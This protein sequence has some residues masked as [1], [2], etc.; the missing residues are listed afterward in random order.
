MSSAAATTEL[1]ASHPEF[2][3]SV[4][5]NG[6]LLPTFPAPSG[7]ARAVLLLVHPRLLFAYW[8]IDEHLDRRLRKLAGSAQLRVEISDGSSPFEEVSRHDFDFRTPH[9]YLHNSFIDSL[10][11]VRLG[12]VVRGHFEELLVSNP[13]R[14]PRETPGDEPEIWMKLSQLRASPPPATELH[15]TRVKGNKPAVKVIGYPPIAKG[16]YGRIFRRL[17][18][19]LRREMADKAF[20]RGY[21]SVVLHSHLPFVRHP[22][23]DYFLEE[24]WL[25]EAITETYLPLL[26]MFDRLLADQ[27]PARVTVSLSPTLVAMLRDPH[28]MGKYERHLNKLCELG[29]KEV[30]RTERDATFGPI[31]RFYL[32]HFRRLRSLFHDRYQRDLVGECA[33]LEE[34]GLLE[35]ITCASTHGFLPFLSVQPE[36]VWAQ[37]QTA[38]EEHERHFGRRPRGIWL[39]ECAYTEGM[40]EMLVDAG[41][42]FF[43]VDSHAVRNASSLPKFGTFAPVYCP[44]GV[45]AFCRDDESSVQ[46]WSSELGYPGDPAYRDFYRDI[47]FDLD[48]SYVGP[49]LDPAGIRGMTGF[50]YYRV[51]GRNNN[52]EPYRR[53]WALS[54]AESHAEDFAKNRSFQLG[55]VAGRMERVPLVCAMYDAELFGHWWFEG[56]EWL[57]MVLRKLPSRRLFAVTPSQYLDL[58]PIGQVAEPAGSSWGEKGY[59]EVWLN[60]SNDWVYPH[61][62]DA[63]RRFLD[64]LGRYPNPTRSIA[65]GLRQAGRELLLGQASD[66]P[67]IL[68]TGTSVGYARRRIHEHLGRLNRLLQQLENGNVDENQIAQMEEADN[69]FP[70]LDPL[71]TWR[72]GGAV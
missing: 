16:K 50:K 59:F 38:L 2:L 51:T 5:G 57:E 20:A 71:R 62:H 49:Y 56:P 53:D 6:D 17:F 42:D 3:P 48:A 63:G 15:P 46:V 43:F 65:R 40:D 28:L 10:V 1:V 52:K 31:A 69:L 41:L 34:E 37:I 13:L 27:V 23:R 39:P 21:V 45:A 70:N 30:A 36:M 7:P 72:V 58:Y 12:M 61:L 66:W 68:R 19:R 9:W 29:E 67:F 24:N 60:G 44:S 8:V 64:L 32:D 33:R 4:E 55:Y 25:F 35:I 14:V 26:E 11:R 18:P 22:E 47:G 54:K